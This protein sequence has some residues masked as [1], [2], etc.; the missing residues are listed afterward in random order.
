M[1]YL[2]KKDP[3]SCRFCGESNL[4]WL[5]LD[6]DIFRLAD[7]DGNLHDCRAFHDAQHYGA[8]GKAGNTLLRDIIAWMKRWHNSM[9]LAAAEELDD[10]LDTSAHPK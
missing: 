5:K 4:Q 7:A 1:S 8:N 9:P 2:R 10:I 3:K 6:E